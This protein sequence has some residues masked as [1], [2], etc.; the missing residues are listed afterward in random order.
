MKKLYLI[1]FLI[2]INFLLLYGKIFSN[3]LKKINLKLKN[4]EIG[5]IILS[6]ET[7]KSLL[8]STQENF[9]LYTFFYEDDKDLEQNISLFTDKLDYVFMKNEYPLSYPY[10][11]L[12][13]GLVVIQDVQLEPNKLHYNNKTFCINETNQCDFVY[14]TEEI[15]FEDSLDAVFYDERLSDSFVESLHKKWIDVYKITV[16]SYTI[17]LFNEDYEVIHLTH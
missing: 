17:L 6:L 15:E 1:I 10:K 4:N 2:L 7:S 14:L 8:I 5:I 11:S 3:K 16:D 9:L 12:L 13:D